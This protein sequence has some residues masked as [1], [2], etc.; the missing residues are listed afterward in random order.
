MEALVISPPTWAGRNVLV[1]GHTG[2]KGSWLSLWLEA[3]GARVTGLALPPDTQPSLFEDASVGRGM[4]SR[5]VDV[6]DAAAVDRLVTEVRPE[7]VFHLAA[8]P[9]VRRSYAEPVLTYATNVMGV[10]HLLD[11]LRRAG[12]ARAV[13]VVTTDKCYE[14]RERPEPYDESEPLGGHDPYSSSKAAAELVA[15][16][17]R[18]SYFPAARFDEHRT[19]LATARA[20]NVIGGGDWSQD[21]LVPDILRAFMAGRRVAIRNP[22]AVRPWQHVLES[23][24]GYILLAEALL[25]G[26]P[27]DAEAFNFGPAEADALPVGEIVR[28]AAAAWDQPGGLRAAG[29]DLDEAPR[30]HE[31]G[32]LR[33]DSSK[34]RQRLGWRPRLSIQEAIRWTVAWHAAA[35]RG[36]D[37]RALV[38]GQ[39][40]AY[41]D[42]EVISP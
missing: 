28:L 38:L 21:R 20:G 29:W 3:L 19:A 14:N 13:V 23:V 31:A 5:L 39:I 6:R 2:F 33:L 36:E 30:P 7:I 22:D 10:V 11:A 9:L 24:A 17:F 1:T 34:A 41:Q 42:L 4:D 12:S 35:A 25:E 37:P 32:L 27:R 40:R 18:Q 16:S 8:Q 15:A 26:G